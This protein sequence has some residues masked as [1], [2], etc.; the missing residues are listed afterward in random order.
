MADDDEMLK[1]GTEPEEAETEEPEELE[2]MEVE[3]TEDGGAVMTIEAEEEPVNPEFYDNLAESMP[4]GALQQIALGLVEDVKRDQE[5][6][7]E[8]DQQYEEGIRRTGL[9]ND[10]PG[11]A[12][13]QGASRVVHPMLTEAC[14]DFAARAMKELFPSAGQDG[15]PVKAQI[16]G[17]PT[18]EKVE[19]ANR[20]ARHLNWQVTKQM[21]GFRSELEQLLSQVPLAGAQ[22]LKLVW[23]RRLKRPKPLFVPLDDVF[24]PYS[25]TSFRTAERKTHRQTITDLEFTRRVATGMYRDIPVP[26]SQAEELSAPA[27][28]NEKVE[29]KASSSM[30]EDG[31]RTI[32]EVYCNLEIEE[33]KE[34]AGE[35]APYVISI[36]SQTNVVLALYR[37]WDPRDELR[38]ELP[39][40]VE[41]PFVPW[42]GAYPIGITHMI[43]GL[44]AATTGALRALLDSAFLQNNP[45]GVKLK[46]GSI[47]GQ[48]ISVQPG[49]TAEIQG[50]PNAVDI[51]QTYMPLPY[52][53][54]SPVLFELLGFLINSGKGVVQTTFEKL[55]DQPANQ[56]VGT[57]VALIEQGMVVFSEIH[58]RLHHAMG[59]T[60]EILHRLNQTYL[61][62]DELF[63]DVGELLAK[64]D[65]YQGPMDV[66]P[67][68]DP[69]IFSETQRMA[70]V[71][72]V[73]GRAQLRPD[74]YD[75]RKVEELILERTKI[76]D[77]KDL[78]L[79]RPEPQKL[80]AVN[81]NLAATMGRPII[82]FPD[83]D[84]LAHLQVHIDYM[85]S[86]MFGMNPL[87]APV[88]LQ[89]MLNHIKDHIGYWYVDSF[90]KFT[91]EA[92]GVDITKLMDPEDEEVGQE[93][94]RML[95]AASPTII[96]IAMQE[97]AKLPP[98]IQQAM[99]VAQQFAPPQMGDPTQAA[100]MAAQASVKEVER[101]A[102]ADQLKGQLDQQRLQMD[103]QRLQI[104]GMSIQMK[105]AEM[106][107]KQQLD[108][109]RAEM[110]QRNADAERAAKLMITERAE[111]AKVGIAQQQAAVKVKTNTDDNQTAMTIAQM[112]V[113]SAREARQE[114]MAFEAQQSAVDRQ[115]DQQNAAAD[116]AFNAQQAAEDRK[117]GAET[118]QVDRMFQAV[119]KQTEREHR[120]QQADKDR[121]FEGEKVSV[122]T[123]GG[124]DP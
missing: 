55:A 9:G 117:H 19:K 64:R 72:M 42:R 86:P 100:M 107:M 61:E 16:I 87:I 5:D 24:L 62:D 35:I 71:Q 66:A 124:I 57:T 67:V 29:G 84:H 13:F 39:W 99:Q 70:Q 109:A 82:A 73:A 68:S 56:P 32:Y 88:L 4:A 115:L 6:R 46:G 93:F 110:E 20:K 18:K 85:M 108:Q 81:E 3:E 52:Q 26:T 60:L 105:Q 53:G 91:S 12:Q 45:A 23:D 83:Q 21:K 63:D 113:E 74:L 89:G 34:A 78:L 17:K 122:S 58:A 44:S 80:N 104:E 69:N 11:G 116:R 31:L 30:N 111:K 33:D 106:Q 119:D 114:S 54:P 43:G 47:G 27:A 48:N 118:K 22:Y 7:E 98:I 15:G 65:D 28:A 38:E 92:A 103:N 101:K 25:A 51:R 112:E 49:N 8:R 102:Q 94:D 2:G 37:N 90:V 40:M 50:T 97:L 59:E 76:P 120:A 121:E 95:A 41:F 123:G 14:V 77:A 96:Q 1:L 75:G 79:P 10:A 36:D